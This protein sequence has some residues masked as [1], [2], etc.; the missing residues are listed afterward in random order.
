[1]KA[2]IDNIE[3]DTGLCWSYLWALE[4]KFDRLFTCHKMSFLFIQIFKHIEAIL[5]LWT[6]EKEV[7]IQICTVGLSWPT[8][9]LGEKLNK[10]R[11]H[12]VCVHL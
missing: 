6:V 5:S 11:I 4:S 1:M 10:N 8:P 3:T 2:A 12:Y 7:V 9:I